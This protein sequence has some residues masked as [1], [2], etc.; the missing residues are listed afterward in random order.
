[1]VRINKRLISNNKTAYSETIINQLFN[2]SKFLNILGIK[3]KNNK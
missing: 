3:G 2:E 1:L